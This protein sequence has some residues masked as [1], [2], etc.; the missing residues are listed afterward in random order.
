MA[1]AP[2][3]PEFARPTTG[4]KMPPEDDALF[5]DAFVFLP[6]CVA[7]PNSAP[8]PDSS[9]PAGLTITC[10]YRDPEQKPMLADSHDPRA[11]R[12]PEVE[13]GRPMLEISPLAAQALTDNFGHVAAVVK[14]DQF[15][16]SADGA[17]YQVYERFVTASGLIRLRVNKVA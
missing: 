10:V 9:R 14:G 17:V 15:Q 6:M 1:K 13:T 3:E 11:N 8:I 2:R 5:G 4:V 16:R 7:G 12:R